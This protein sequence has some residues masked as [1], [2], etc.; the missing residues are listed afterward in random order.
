MAVIKHPA[1]R[2]GVFIDTQ[3]LYHSAKHLYKSRVNFANVL[4]EAVGD[5]LLVRAIAYVINTENGDETGRKFMNAQTP[6]SGDID[7]SG[8]HIVGALT[9]KFRK[10]CCHRPGERLDMGGRDGVSA[11][12]ATPAEYESAGRVEAEVVEE[13]ARVGNDAA[14]RQMRHQGDE[15]GAGGNRSRRAGGDDRAGRRFFAPEI[16]LVLQQPVAPRGDIDRP[17]GAQDGGPG[18]AEDGE[19]IHRQLP[20]PRQIAQHQ[21]VEIGEVAA[22]RLRLV[23]QTAE[24]GGKPHRILPAQG[25]AIGLE[26]W[27]A[28][29]HQAGQQEL[30]AQIHPHSCRK[31]E[32]MAEA[33]S[34]LDPIDASRILGVLFDI[35]STSDKF[36][37]S[38]ES[39]SSKR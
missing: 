33:I 12:R 4:A 27:P 37:S 16:G 24:I 35:A 39:L 5:R 13:P 25:L 26:T 28:R 9:G 2:V 30:A 29:H 18:I 19:E 11:Q 17:L 6:V 10:R 23:Q 3:N 36:A 1:Q 31:I 22:F 20:M 8:P 32:R 7:V 21:P 38:L 14:L 34:P 15:I